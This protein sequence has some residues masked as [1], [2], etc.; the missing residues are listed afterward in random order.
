MIK[1]GFMA[2]MNYTITP[3]GFIHTPYTK[4]K[5]DAP[6]QSVETSQ[7]EF[8]VEVLN[9]HTKRL[10]KLDSFTYIYLIYWLDRIQKVPEH[11][12]SPPWTKNT[13]VGLFAS[14]SPNRINPI[15]LSIVKVKKIINN[16]IEIS[17]IDAFDNTPLLDIKPYI[18][19]LDAKHDANYGWL[20]STD[21]NSKDHLLLHIKGVPHDH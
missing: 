13:K 9:E 14:R 17:G 18:K 19:D 8:Y 15:G 12:V 10:D 4:E 6:F 11:L 1:Q 7:G 16:R 20:E 21:T 3:I 5:G 2:C